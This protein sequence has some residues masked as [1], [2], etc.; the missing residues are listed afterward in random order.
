M[1]GPPGST[2][3]APKKRKG[4]CAPINAQRVPSTG[5]TPPSSRPATAPLPLS[6]ARPQN[7]V[8]P[9]PVID[10]MR[11]MTSLHAP[12]SQHEASG[13]NWLRKHFVMR[14]D[15][16]DSPTSLSL[17]PRGLINS[18]NACFLNAVM[19]AIVSLPP[20]AHLLASVASERDVC[21]LSSTIGGWLSGTYAKSGSSM[22]CP[23]P[24]LSSSMLAGSTS[25][26]AVAKR[27]ALDGR[28]QQDAHEF[29]TLLLQSMRTEI[30]ALEADAL[31]QAASQSSVADGEKGKKQQPAPEQSL[32]SAGSNKGWIT[33]GRGGKE[34]MS[35]HASGH[36][37]HA[38]NDSDRLWRCFFG[39]T[40]QSM[41]RGGANA[42]VA[43]SVTSVTSEPFVCLCL[44]VV[45][46]GVGTPSVADLIEHTY[47]GTETIVNAERGVEMRRR[48]RI[49][50]L[51]L[52]LVI[53]LRR[54]AVTAEGESVKLDNIVDFGIDLV[55][56]ASTCAVDTS[57]KQRSYQLMSVVCHRGESQSSGHYVTY[58]VN[59]GRKHGGSD[60]GVANATLCNDTKVTQSS[61]SAAVK[62]T[63]YFLFFMR[64]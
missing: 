51:P 29:L 39:G 57:I 33:V 40:V 34:K 58:V 16:T 47:S 6:S 52:I 10:I 43:K 1:N 17:R 30:C 9:F 19:Q 48:Q 42:V 31:L 62:D 27:G 4:G 26:A 20:L 21:P 41:L 46:N 55:V 8:G 25:S 13:S 23:P 63:P 32:T 36:D 64:K 5:D 35:I 22:C 12:S 11:V 3:V 44:D 37:D 7:A 18:A 45:G 24:R 2:L 56:P 15:S 50:S 59:H 38:R 49:G 14:Y 61:I 28:I 53:Q 60:E 54:W